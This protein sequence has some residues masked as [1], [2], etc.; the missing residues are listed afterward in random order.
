MTF[1]IKMGKNFRRK[2]SMVAR[3]HTMVTPAALTY[4]SVVSCNSVQIILLIVALND[5]KIL[6]SDI[7]NAY[8]TA[9]CREKIWCRAGPE[10]GAEDQGKIML[11]TR[12][13]YGLKSS[14]AAFRSLLAD[15]IW[16]LGYRPSKADHD[17]W[18]RP[19]VKPSGMQYYEYVMTYVDDVI[20]IGHDPMKTM[21]GINSYF[22]FK[23]D[24]IEEPDIYLGAG[25]SKI[26]TGDGT[27]CWA[28]SSDKYCASAVKN[29]E[30]VLQKKG[31][32]LP[33]KCYTPLSSGYRPE[34]DATAELKA[35]GVQWYQELIGM[36]RWA[37][38]IGRVDILFETAIMSKHM[39]LPREGH[40]E[41]LL[42]IYGYLKQKK[43]LRIAFD[44]DQP[45]I[46]PNRFKTYDWEDFYKGV[47]EDI[48][49]DM[50]RS[51]GLAISIS[52]FVDANHAGNV[53]NRRSQT[54]I[55]IFCNKAPIH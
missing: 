47:K 51:R 17:V 20:A 54:G 4:S 40:L 50:P 55:L 44:P 42:H 33:S 32:R 45:Q 34:L 2:A 7:Q 49:P 52:A 10:F 35:G 16:E 43:K 36:L 19:A 28:M 22:K 23:N 37:V 41:Q 39:A 29:V 30:E 53:A 11:I 18:L 13:L 15:K 48:P 38:E 31:I 3:G 8:L 25:L 21:K 14:G 9:K 46:N 26:V 27:E 12:A 1:D 24:K 5:L 6:S